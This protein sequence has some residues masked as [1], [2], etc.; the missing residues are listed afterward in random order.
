MLCAMAYLNT[1][2]ALVEANKSGLSRLDLMSKS[3]QAHK[4][5]G[6]AIMLVRSTLWLPFPR[7]SSL[8]SECLHRPLL[9]EPGTPSTTKDTMLGDE[10]RQHMATTAKC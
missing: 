7:S 1:A 8:P 4:Q 9:L 10:K 6:E 3:Q 5:R 2:Q